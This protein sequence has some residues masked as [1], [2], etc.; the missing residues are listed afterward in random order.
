MSE[1][2]ESSRPFIIYINVLNFFLR[3]TKIHHRVYVF[4]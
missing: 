2:N 3:E 4:E 1:Y